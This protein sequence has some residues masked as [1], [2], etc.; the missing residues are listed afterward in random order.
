MRASC[1]LLS[2]HWNSSS[3]ASFDLLIDLFLFGHLPFSCLLRFIVDAGRLAAYATA[4]SYRTRDWFHACF[5]YCTVKWL[6]GAFIVHCVV[7]CA[8]RFFCLSRAK[9]NFSILARARSVCNLLIFLTR[10]KQNKEIK[11]REKLMKF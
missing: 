6:P 10:S 7:H 3:A 11:K 9:A 2:H 4:S 8:L 5:W 1:I